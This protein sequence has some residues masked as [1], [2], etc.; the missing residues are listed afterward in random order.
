MAKKNKKIIA[1]AS[2]LL[3]AFLIYHY[4]FKAQMAPPQDIKVV[5]VEIVGLKDISQTTRLIG[6]I[7]AKYP[8]E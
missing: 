7:K 4:F 6:T 8:T 2:L 5:E 1:P 3:V